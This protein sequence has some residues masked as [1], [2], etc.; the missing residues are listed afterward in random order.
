MS[1]LLV[2]SSQ[3]LVPGGVE[4]K[5]APSSFVQRFVPCMSLSPEYMDKCLNFSWRG[6]S[7]VFFVAE[8]DYISSSRFY[9]RILMEVLWKCV[10]SGLLA[11]F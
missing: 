3:R 11:A 7:I 9:N 8:F 10:Q 5:F 4:F 2:R 6:Y 1:C